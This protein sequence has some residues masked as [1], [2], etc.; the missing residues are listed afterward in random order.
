MAK[1]CAFV[2]GYV[3]LELLAY[4]TAYAAGEI[5]PFW[6][7]PAGLALGTLVR[8][9]RR[10]WPVLLLPLAAVVFGLA[11]LPHLAGPALPAPVA[12]VWALANTL[13]A[14]VGAWVMRTAGGRPFSLRRVSEVL[15]WLAGGVL[16]T[17]LLATLLLL[18]V[19][20]IWPA[21]AP[22][23]APLQ[24]WAA[25]SFGLLAISPLVL[26]APVRGEWPRP[27]VHRV[28]EVFLLLVAL[29]VATWGTFALPTRGLQ[30]LALGGSSTV[31]LAWAAFRF[32]PRGAAWAMACLGALAGWQALE[33]GGPFAEPGAE[34][35]ALRAF[36]TQAY[37]ALVTIGALLLAALAAER[38]RAADRQRLVLEVGLALSA[39]TALPERLEQAAACIVRLLARRCVIRLDGSEFVAPHESSASHA[40]EVLVERFHGAVE[41]GGIEVEAPAELGTFDPEARTTVAHL[42]ARIA[43]A[44][45]QDRLASESRRQ[46]RELRHSEERFRRLAQATSDVVWVTD[47][48]L[49]PLS[50]GEAWTALTGHTL[51]DFQTGRWVRYMPPEDLAR[52]VEQQRIMLREGKP[53]RNYRYRILVDGRWHTHESSGV[54]VRN[55]DGSIREWVGMTVDV[56]DRVAAEEAREQALAEAQEAVRIRDDFLSVASHELKTPL[57]PLAA[58]LQTMER[59]AV[60]GEPIDPAAIAK[61]RAGLE[62]LKDLIDDLLDVS[63]IRAAARLAVRREPFALAEA[64][65]EVADAYREHDEAHRLE[66]EVPEEALLVAGDRQRIVQV[67]DIL[68]DNAF[69][70]SPGGGRVGI[71]LAREGREAILAVSDEGIGIPPADQGRI[72]ERFF[73][74]ENV[75]ASSYG[76]LGLGLYITRDVVENHGG[77]IWLRSEPGRGSTF[78]VALPLLEE[79]QAPPTSL[80]TS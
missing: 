16:L 51:D 5:S 22:P 38:R 75:S 17:S 54:P 24:R 60:A 33:G 68:V 10:A 63:R 15:L 71:T 7:P 73:R 3:L 61:A 48:H 65:R 55:E 45:E 50:G 76:G 36:Y 72:F 70:F 49:A 77:R 1:V 12:A 59:R 26:T 43:E 25:Q 14:A 6:W 67:L 58:R 80:A 41:E 11:R 64:V 53:Y 79:L 30:L 47:P 42:A 8:A 19:W 13:P 57:T 69:K 29:L 46:E 40:T 20:P 44:A 9:P 23:L 2:V 56:T 74:A 39:R 66:V 31:V 62:R 4:E 18:L 52:A 27:F 28:P 37:F 35:P 21:D 32:G 34:L 78:F